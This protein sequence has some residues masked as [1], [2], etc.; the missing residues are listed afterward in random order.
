MACG[1]EIKERAD[2]TLGTSVCD[3]R[4]PEPSCCAREPPQVPGSRAADERPH[5]VCLR[6]W[7]SHEHLTP[8]HARTH[9]ARHPPTEPTIIWT[10][11]V[12][13]KQENTRKRCLPYPQAL[14][15][16][17]PSFWLGGLFSQRLLGCRVCFGVSSLE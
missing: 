15:I 6:F 2:V 5:W 11:A 4:T 1:Q 9:P 8:P 17:G 16:G 7:A 10:R 3:C 14:S 13:Q 12:A